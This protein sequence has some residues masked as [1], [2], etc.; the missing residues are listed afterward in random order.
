M[1]GRVFQ[2][3]DLSQLLR[4][5]DTK[6]FQNSDK[7][8]PS[9]NIAP[10]EYLPVIKFSHPNNDSSQPK[11]RVLDIMPWGYHSF[12]R[13]LFNA[14]GEDPHQKKS[15]KTMINSSRCAVIV[16]GYFQWN[17][18]KE[19]FLFRPK[20]F[21]TTKHDKLPLHLL[22]A[23]MQASDGSVIILTRDA[24]SNTSHIHN[25]TPVL[26]DQAELEKW[27]NCDKYKFENIRLDILNE[28]SEKWKLLFFYQV[29]PYVSNVKDKSEKVLTKAVEY[30]TGQEKGGILKFFQ[31]AKKEKPPTKSEQASPEK[32]VEGIF[33]DDG[34]IDENEVEETPKE[35][36]KQDEQKIT[37]ILKPLS[38]ESKEKPEIK[39][40]EEQS[41]QKEENVVE[42]KE[43]GKSSKKRVVK[44]N[45]ES[46]TK[47][48]QDDQI[49]EA[50]GE[51]GKQS[52][53]KVGKSS[54][55][56]RDQ[57]DS[58]SGKSS[59]KSEKNELSPKKRKEFPGKYSD[60]VQPGVK[61]LKTQNLQN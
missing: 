55:V 33:Q 5:A 45:V 56:V 12:E 9:Y 26:L 6:H 59:P 16:E 13:L 52:K 36:R 23:G 2:T 39:D 3:Y 40:S 21:V 8:I 53:K 10:T 58:D 61:K 11:S 4:I 14:R 22:L 20:N 30:H 17:T 34:E 31:S 1:C 32:P 49:Q 42:D 38:K 15:F 19:P 37:I 35:N 54:K 46:P 25:R 57:T 50:D 47:S 28:K 24:L 48:T 43:E 41:S 51:T 44:K 27:I 7:Y 60:N 18:K 29:A